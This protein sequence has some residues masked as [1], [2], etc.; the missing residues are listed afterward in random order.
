[1]PRRQVVTQ[2]STLPAQA[3][4]TSVRSRP[5]LRDPFERQELQPPLQTPPRGDTPA[6]DDTPW[7]AGDNEA[8]DSTWSPAHGA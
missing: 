3:T 4:G 5:I 8:A 6:R 1:M 2:R 7:T